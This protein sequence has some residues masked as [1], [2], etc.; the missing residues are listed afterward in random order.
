[1]SSRYQGPIIDA[2]HH[3]WD[4]S[5]GRHPWLTSDDSAIKALGDISYMRRNYLVEDLI[6]DIGPQ[7]V[8]GP[9][10]SRPHGTVRGHPSKK[11]PGSKASRG[12]AASRRAASPGHRSSRPR[13]RPRSK[14]SPGTAAS[15]ASAKSSV[16][17][18]I[19]PNAGRK[20]AFSMLPRGGKASGACALTDLSSS[21]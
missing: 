8:V 15:S 21:S 10:M 20:P 5:L 16:G 6:A 13:P 7:N 3:L 12:Q 14:R 17:I 1:M 19:R 18:P 11:S 9:S 2:H 4:L